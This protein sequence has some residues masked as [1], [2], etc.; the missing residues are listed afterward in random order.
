MLYGACEFIYDGTQFHLVSPAI[1]YE[2]IGAAASGHGHSGYCT[3]L[4]CGTYPELGA[5][6][7]DVS[8]DCYENCFIKGIFGSNYF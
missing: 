7:Y 2:T 8:D 1:T 3:V 4:E 6:K 5:L